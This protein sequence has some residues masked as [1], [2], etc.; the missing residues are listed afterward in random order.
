MLKVIVI[1][2]HLTPIEFV[3]SLLQ[4]IFGHSKEVAEKTALLAH[5]NGEAPCGICREHAE[6]NNLVSSATALSRQTGYPL[7]F[8]ILPLPFW[9]RAVGYLLRMVM[10][11]T[12]GSCI[13]LAR[14]RH[15]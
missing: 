1:S 6:A 4:E 8:A 3:A 13:R 5:L 10:K 11:V 7:G 15:S 12:P 14:S 2:D 9:E